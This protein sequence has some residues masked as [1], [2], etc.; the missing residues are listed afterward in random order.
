VVGV[1]NSGAVETARQLS[2][3]RQK[4]FASLRPGERWL[5]CVASPS[6]EQKVTQEAL[7]KD[8]R[9][10]IRL[11]MKSGSHRT[12]DRSLLLGR[13]DSMSFQYDVDCQ[14]FLQLLTLKLY[15]TRMSRK[16]TSNEGAMKK[17]STI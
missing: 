5:G 14:R 3:R 11:L 16:L 2:G 12:P 13:Q 8:A 10:G 6:S 7:R 4:V 17:T 15:F 9:I 1:D